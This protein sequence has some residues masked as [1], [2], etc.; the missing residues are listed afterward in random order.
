MVSVIRVI[1]PEDCRRSFFKACWEGF[2]EKEQEHSH[3][4]SGRVVTSRWTLLFAAQG[5]FSRTFLQINSVI[6]GVSCAVP[7]GRAGSF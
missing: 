6:P 4:E 5:F 3:G 2:K 7:K 1:H